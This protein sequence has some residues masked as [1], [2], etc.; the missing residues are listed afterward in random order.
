MNRN[1]I[2]VFVILLAVTVA[3]VL[4]GVSRDKNR[5]HHK[6]NPYDKRSKKTVD[7]V[8]QEEDFDW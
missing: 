3:F 4:T 6:T 7:D 8:W 1:T 2:I 5:Y